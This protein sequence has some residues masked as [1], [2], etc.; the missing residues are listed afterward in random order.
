MSQKSNFKLATQSLERFAESVKKL[1]KNP[2]WGLNTKVDVK[3]VKSLNCEI[4]EDPKEPNKD[5]QQKLILD[6]LKEGKEVSSYWGFQHGIIRLTNRVNE[7]RNANWNIQDYWMKSASG[8]RFKVYYL[9]TK[10]ANS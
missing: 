4:L 6:A 3:N 7:L 2:F 8:K 10:K 9:E 5:T 1:A